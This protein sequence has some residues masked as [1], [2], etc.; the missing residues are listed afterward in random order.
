MRTRET[1]HQKSP[2]S[3]GVTPAQRAFEAA[4]ATVQDDFVEALDRATEARRVFRAAQ[5]ELN[6]AVAD[7]RTFHGEIDDQVSA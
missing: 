2:T 3:A 1:S 4:A 5:S 6:A 7:L